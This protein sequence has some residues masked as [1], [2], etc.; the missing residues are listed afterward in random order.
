MPLSDRE[1]QILSDIEARLR[2]ED[3]KFARTVATTTVSTYAKRQVKFAAIGFAI[4][5][6][7]LF[8]IIAHIGWGIAG[9]ALMLA[10][11]I[12]GGN[13]LKRIG[14]DRA[15]VTSRQIRGGIS[16]YFDDRRDDDP[17]F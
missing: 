14:Q 10:C 16:R 8:G 6:F 1:Q 4:G 13:Q 3:P 5:F 2:E 15:D 12:Y 9:S 7:M 11:A 17:R